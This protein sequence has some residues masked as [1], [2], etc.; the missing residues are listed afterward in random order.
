NVPFS[1]TKSSN[2]PEEEAEIAREK[3]I[4]GLLGAQNESYNR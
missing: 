1:A 3:D 4:E 2:L